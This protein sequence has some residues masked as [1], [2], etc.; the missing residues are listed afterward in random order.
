MHERKTA[1]SDRFGT[2]E[3]ERAQTMAKDG[4]K[5]YSKKS[6]KESSQ[7]RKKGARASAEKKQQK[8]RRRQV[9]DVERL[10]KLDERIQK[11]ELEF[12]VMKLKQSRK[13]GGERNE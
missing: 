2:S 11:L 13:F 10:R 5:N 3:Q 9:Y 8:D 1:N 6:R 4:R 7:S 12:A